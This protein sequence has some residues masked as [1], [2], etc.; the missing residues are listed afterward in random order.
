MDLL[1]SCTMK[2]AGKSDIIRRYPT[3]DS[4]IVWMEV[5]YLKMIETIFNYHLF[6][7]KKKKKKNLINNFYFFT[8]NH[9][10]LK[11]LNNS[12]FLL[13]IKKIKKK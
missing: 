3:C 12:F 5:P 10:F 6:L 1:V 13:K 8:N 9:Y 11:N 7:K 4:V 2:N